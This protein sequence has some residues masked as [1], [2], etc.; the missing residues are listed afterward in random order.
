[1]SVRVEA[2]CA[3]ILKISIHVRTKRTKTMLKV[4]VIPRF[5]KRDKK[6]GETQPRDE[7]FVILCVLASILITTLIVLTMVVKQQG[8]Q[9]MRLNETILTMERNGNQ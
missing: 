9:I 3:D 7:K 1:M 4:Q 6:E 8:N 5:P 2:V